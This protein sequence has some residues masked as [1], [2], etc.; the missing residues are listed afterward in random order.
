MNF[1]AKIGRGITYFNT[2]VAFVAS[3]LIFPL[4]ALIVIEVFRRYVLGNP[5]VFAFDLQW[6]ICG[7]LVFFGGA[8]ALADNVHVRADILYNML[9]KRWQLL[10]DIVLYPL[11]FFPFLF[12]LIYALHGLLVNAWIWGEVSPVTAWRPVIW[13]SRLILLLA[14]SLLA[15]QGVVKYLTL[16]GNAKRDI[17]ADDEARA[18][19]AADA[20]GDDK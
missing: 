14:M 4:I 1:L 11:F 12:V 13:P 16:I 3:L 6:M 9:R 7:T 15:L 17:K 5:S 18:A 10:I 19:K 20:G 8:Y 2:K